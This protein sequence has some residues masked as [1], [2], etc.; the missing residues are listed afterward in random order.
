MASAGQDASALGQGVLGGLATGGPVGAAIGA[1]AAI[2]TLFQ[3]SLA[4]VQ[5]E[6]AT[7][8]VNALEPLFAENRDLVL[9]DPTP[10]NIQ[11]GITN[12]NSMWLT[13]ASDVESLAKAG[14]AAINDR[15]PGGKFDWWKLYLTP[16]EQAIPKPA[17]VPVSSAQ[18]GLVSNYWTGNNPPNPTNPSAVSSS[19]PAPAP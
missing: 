10:A 19:Q 14:T 15:A 1:L 17:S 2:P 13:M 6:D 4:G 11:Q 16:I 3:T 8:V 9:Q 12:F 7:T 5:K 18:L